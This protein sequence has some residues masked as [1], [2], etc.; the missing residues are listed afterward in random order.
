MLTQRN[1]SSGVVYLA[2]PL[3]ASAE[4]PHGFSTRMG[5]VSRGA[6]AALNLGNPAGSVRDDDAN[7]T[8]NYR[9]FAHAAGL[10]GRPLCRVH[11]VHSADV[12]VV[13]DPASHDG[14]RQADALVT[15]NA[16][17]AL[18]IRTADC[19]PLLLA[20]TNGKW[21]A[22]VHA[23]WRGIVAGVLP[24]AIRRLCDVSGAHRV[25]LLLAIG[26]CISS[27]RFEVGPE[28][29]AEFRRIFADETPISR[30]VGQKAYIDLAMSLV[31]QAQRSGI[32]LSRIDMTDLCTYEDSSLFFSHRRDNGITGRM[33]SVI[34][35]RG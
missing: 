32:D 25:D 30:T 24:A 17:V 28:V 4:V 19:V 5:G 13:R 31:L 7:L 27:E 34:A 29:T 2:S 18:S 21:V 3:L 26:P 20:T 10:D 12:C 16:G 1:D 11:Q 8:E 23:G 35:P 6:F 14:S 9:R 22:A 15:G 33:A